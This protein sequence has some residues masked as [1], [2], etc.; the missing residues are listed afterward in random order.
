ME[1]A[2]GTWF[3][4]GAV[5]LML[6]AFAAMTFVEWVHLARGFSITVS[7]GEGPSETTHVVFPLWRQMTPFV[8]S[9]LIA[10]VVVLWRFRNRAA[11]AL[12]WIAVALLLGVQIDDFFEYGLGAPGSILTVL[13]VVT[14]ALVTTFARVKRVT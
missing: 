11:T 4:R 13:I 2:T 3:I 6:A 12:A 1:P 8:E 9:A 14:L 5:A 7:L 10:L